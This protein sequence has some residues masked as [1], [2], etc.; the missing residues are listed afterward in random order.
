MLV[1][2]LVRVLVGRALWQV[3]CWWRGFR[4]EVDL[5]LF[6]HVAWGILVCLCCVC[7]LLRV[8]RVPSTAP[9]PAACP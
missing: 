2:P 7:G 6:R 3:V 9:I 4:I 8:L 1:H 5:V